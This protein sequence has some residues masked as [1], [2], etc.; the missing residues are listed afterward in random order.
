[1]Q[2][3]DNQHAESLSKG[4]QSQIRHAARKYLI[5]A[6]TLTPTVHTTVKDSGVMLTIRYIV[7]PRQRRGTKQKMWKKILETFSNRTED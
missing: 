3:I 4:A 2:E 7:K 1:M 5:V 6:S